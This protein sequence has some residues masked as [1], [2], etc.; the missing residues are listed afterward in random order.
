MGSFG[1]PTLS[2]Y[3]I[4]RSDFSIILNI[5]NNISVFVKDIDRQPVVTAE[6]QTFSINLVDYDAQILLLTRDL[7]LVDPTQGLYSFIITPADTLQWQLG[8]LSYTITVNNP[9]GSQNVLWTDRDY[10]PYGYCTVTP[11][12]IPAPAQPII[13]NVP[14]FV[15]TDG[16]ATT[17]QLPGSVFPNGCMT[18]AF[19]CTAFCGVIYVQGSLQ[20]QPKDLSDWFQ[21]ETVNV[22]QPTTGVVSTTITGNYAFLRAQIPVS[23]FILDPNLMLP[24]VTGVVNQVIY[25]N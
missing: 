5:T 13:M 3:P 17:P 9:D 10:T 1:A 2:N 22:S 4:T 21:I 8:P 15:I 20:Q 11:G 19:Y 6:G 24:I 23:E 7:V 12:P 14:D 18:F 16:W 25:K